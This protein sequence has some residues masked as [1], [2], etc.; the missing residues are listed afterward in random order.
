MRKFILLVFIYITQEAVH[1]Q[2]PE[3]LFRFQTDNDFMNINLKGTDRAYTGGTRLEYFYTGKPG[4]IHAGFMPKAGQSAINVYGIS[5]SQ[6]LYT[7]EN[8]ASNEY[9]PDDYPYAGALFITHSLLSSSPDDKYSVHTEIIAGLRGKAA[10]GEETQT[11]LHR[12]VDNKEPKGWDHQLENKMLLNLNLTTEKLLLESG[13][14]MEVIAGGG[15]Q[16]GSMNSGATVHTLIRVGKMNPYFNGLISRHT[17]LNEAKGKMQFYFF[18]K[19]EAGYTLYNCMVENPERSGS[20][21]SGAQQDHVS[22]GKFFTGLEYGMI[23][24]QGRFSL[25][26]SERHLSSPRQGLY[27]HV[28]GNISIGYNW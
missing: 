26:V 8:I 9:I 28:Y 6:M 18:I 16:L 14:N 7:P 11:G 2:S 27:A 4:D 3:R 13:G 12:L 23:L 5:L 22:R 10:F 21:D 1:A 17:S 15:F 19:P 25:A 24:S 20:E